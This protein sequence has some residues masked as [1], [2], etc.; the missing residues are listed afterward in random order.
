M[1]QVA[2]YLYLA[3]FWNSFWVGSFEDGK[4]SFTSFFFLEVYT[5]ICSLELLM[6]ILFNSLPLPFMFSTILDSRQHLFEF[7]FWFS[8]TRL[9]GRR[10]GSAAWPL[11]RFQKCKV[12]SHLHTFSEG[13]KTSFIWCSSRKFKFGQKSNVSFSVTEWQFA[14]NLP[15]W[16]TFKKSK[17]CLVSLRGFLGEGEIC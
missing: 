5:I 11:S 4:R 12:I 15:H 13:F 16:R 9:R 8:T 3:E 6:E 1:Y 7:S 2:W 17:R 14:H 10:F